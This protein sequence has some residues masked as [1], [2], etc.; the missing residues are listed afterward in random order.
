MR[1]GGF[2]YITIGH[3][4]PATGH[5]EHE[6]QIPSFGLGVWQMSEGGECRS[7]VKHAINNGYR[8]I[9]TARSYA[10]ETETGAAIRDSGVAREE[11]FVVTKLRRPHSGLD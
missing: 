9:D 2:D 7:A 8:L 3:T 11:I 4:N 10:N 6:V 1:G 5:R